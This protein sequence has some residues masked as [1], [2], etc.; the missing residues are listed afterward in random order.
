MYVCFFRVLLLKIRY[1]FF[2][3]PTLTDTL[4]KTLIGH[5]SYKR[6][7]F[8]LFR[9]FPGAYHNYQN[10]SSVRCMLEVVVARAYSWNGLLAFSK[11]YP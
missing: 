10:L 8:V 11:G 7:L 1:P 2:I 3:S 6:A 5:S 4:L 9:N